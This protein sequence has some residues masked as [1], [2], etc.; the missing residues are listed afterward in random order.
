MQG[1]T[2]IYLWRV[3]PK[4]AFFPSLWTFHNHSQIPLASVHVDSHFFHE[5]IKIN[6]NTL[7]ILNPISCHIIV[8][9]FYFFYLSFPTYMKTSIFAGFSIS[10]SLILRFNY[11]LPA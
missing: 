9:W 4:F 5:Q 7:I 3:T 10:S 1:K 11:T 8:C 2:S 6:N